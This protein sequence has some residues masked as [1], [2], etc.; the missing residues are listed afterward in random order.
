MT[1][2]S[3]LF[4]RARLLKKVVHILKVLLLVKE[5]YLK[6]KTVGGTLRL[7]YTFI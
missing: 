7:T 4:G 6:I 5:S 1:V 3:V 2:L